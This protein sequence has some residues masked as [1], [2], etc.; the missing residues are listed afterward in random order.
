MVLEARGLDVTPETISRFQSA[1]DEPS[2][3]IL[4]RIL[5]DEIR[6][7]RAG[8]IWFE[9]GCSA[10]GFCARITLAFSRRAPFPRDD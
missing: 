5:T 9:F 7:V 3:R 8:T 2:A 1:R 4:Q 6:H 10:K